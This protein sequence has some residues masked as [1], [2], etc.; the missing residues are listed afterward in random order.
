LQPI[1]SLI[2]DP[3][4]NFI[5]SGSEDAN[6]HVWSLPNLISFSKTSSAGQDQL[7]SN[8]PLRTFPNHRAPITSL[9]VGHSS[10]RS[11]IAI[12]TSRDKTAIVWEYRT[13][14]LLRTFL[15]PASPLCLAVDPAD[16]AFYVGYE[17]GSVQI[18][19][20]F[21]TPS[22]QNA[23]Y[24]ERLQSTPIQL[25]PNERWLPPSPELGAAACLTLSYDG[26]T[27]LS[28]HKDGAVGCWD[29]ARGRYASTIT[30][31]NCPITNLQML[32]PTDTQHLQQTSR[33]VVHN[34]VKPRYDYALSNTSQ[35]SDAVPVNYTINTQLRC[36]SPVH[37][38]SRG[39]S[40]RGMRNDEFDASTPL[41][42]EFAIALTHPFFP[43]S[44]IS[45]GL[46]E[47]ASLQ[48]EPIVSQSNQ[49]E[50]EQSSD[51]P[52]I[53]SLEEEVASLKKQVS[54]QESARNVD[55]AETLKLR[56]YIA[57]LEDYNKELLNRQQRAQQ[58][59]LE[60]LARKEQRDLK[61]REAWFEAE[62]KGQNGDAVIR[63]ME[64]EDG[65][66][67][68]ETDEMSSDDE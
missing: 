61:R 63:K 45:E 53:Q 52:R 64:M 57:R 25:S 16:R 40:G 21:K 50:S 24:D 12:S 1:T 2:V 32:P 6:I 37:G 8:S 54:I 10:N 66:E 33:I 28:G 59:R 49:Q 31:F 55:I 7:S 9:A 68:S 27:L 11:N 62:K 26:M 22:I 19:D 56:E 34:V 13:G 42:D 58:A 48:R 17:D 35:N 38:I 30:N 14:K 43:S 18:A 46:A 20:F 23:L 5:L 4:C 51:H 67:T 29:I 65:E 47:L 60:R 41:I 15:L 39:K 44:L 3:T 36:S